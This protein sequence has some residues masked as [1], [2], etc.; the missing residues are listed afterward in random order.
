MSYEN[1]SLKVE[2]TIVSDDTNNQTVTLTISNSRCSLTFEAYGGISGYVMNMS[3]WGLSP[4]KLAKVIGPGSLQLQSRVNKIRVWAN[5]NLLFVGLISTASIDMNTAPDIPLIL[6]CRASAIAQYTPIGPTQFDTSVTFA[7]AVQ[8][9]ANKLGW[10]TNN[11]A[12]D[13]TITPTILTGDAK[14]QM[15]ALS[16][17][18]GNQ[19]IRLECGFDYV[20]ILQYGAP[21][22]NSTITVSDAAGLI[23]YPVYTDNG[24]AFSCMFSPDILTGRTVSLS[25]ALP[26]ATGDWYIASAVHELTSW[27][28]GGAWYSHV[29]CTKSGGNAS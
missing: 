4:D 17:A 24:L 13:F 10:K 1:R 23:G 28:D 29:T 18:Y 15:L 7:S 19:N 2:I 26:N 21:R 5:D 22:D 9:I 8:T 14:T 27:I 12:K 20:D 16:N 3:L 6:S 11:Y 25:T